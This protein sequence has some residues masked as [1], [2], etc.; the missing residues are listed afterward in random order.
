[1]LES[2]PRRVLLAAF[3]LSIGAA[4][5]FSQRPA[6]LPPDAQVV[7]DSL[8]DVVLLTHASAATLGD[9][10][11]SAEWFRACRTK[12]ALP[13]SDSLTVIRSQPWDWSAT[14][15]VDPTTVTVLVS[16]TP[17]NPVDCAASAAATAAAYARGFR[18]TGDTAYP[19]DAAI[20][21]VNV[22]RG[23]TMLTPIDVERVAAT[24]LTVRGLVTVSSA[25]VRVSVPIDGFAPDSTGRT[26]DV[27]LEIIAADS[28]L[29]HRIHLPWRVIRPIWEQM[30]LA[31]AQRASAELGASA[32]MPLETISR[33]AS[34][35]AQRLDARVGLGN[36]L[37][38][39]GDVAAA[40]VLLGQAV[41]EEPCLTLGASMD[42]TA[43]QVVE[44]VDRPRDRCR[45]NM[46]TTLA[47]ATLLP[48]FGQIHSTPRRIYA[49]A[50]LATVASTL[51]ASQSTN[52][53]AER[54]YAR[55]LAVDN[56]DPVLAAA[57]AAQLYDDAESKRLMGR[58]LVAIGVGI[59]GASILEA[60]I[61]ERR[62]I[63]R[64][65]RVRGYQ[66]RQRVSVMPHASPTRVGL[67]VTFF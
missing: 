8:F 27:E 61:S 2:V 67:A 52:D 17:R 21:A 37:A 6:A 3:A 5:A 48:G 60:A 31:R 18:V 14:G 32:V 13:A 57:E 43:R 33:S 41:Q 56:A 63:R 24:R 34:T 25:L 19:Y 15:V 54:L 45:A 51:A 1:M 58:D 9:G 49:V 64:L 44:A 22:R 65:D 53:E 62:L 39:A 46:T 20:T 23:A 50:V 55:Y 7:S 12:L 35:R 42:A 30:L 16:R 4:P 29:P 10:R 36:A 59:W 66:V 40:R 47:R 38:S 11:R 26:R 28:I